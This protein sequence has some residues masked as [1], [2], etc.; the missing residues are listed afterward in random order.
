MTET[1]SRSLRCATVVLVLA[2]AFACK[3]GDSAPPVAT[4][5]F[6]ASKPRV[7]LGS[8]VELTYR[9]DIAPNAAI[10]GDYRVFVHVN[11]P[12]GNT[13]WSDDHEPPTPTSQWK[14]GQKIE[15]TRTKFVP[16]VPYLGDATVEVGLYKENDRL[17]MQGADPADRQS[18]ARSYKVGTLHFLPQSDNIF[19]L[20]KSGWHPAEFSPDDPSTSWQWTQKTG[21]ISIRNPKTD[22]MLDLE[23][24]A[25]PDLFPGAPQQVTVYAGDQVVK[26]FTA[27]ATSPAL[28]RIPVAAAQLGPNEMTDI[29]IDLDKTFTP[30]KLPAGGRDNRELGIRVYHVFVEGR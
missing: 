8:P 15:Y 3:K 19:T 1:F 2:A 6:T 11:S 22:V 5:S 12:D 10:A 4:V 14:P 17:P 23:Y 26:T 21:V 13:L 27:D 25:R 18:T 7:T 30:A 29:R 20:M 16:V 24:D 28:L 9:F